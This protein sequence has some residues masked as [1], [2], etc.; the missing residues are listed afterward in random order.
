MWLAKLDTENELVNTEEKNIRDRI[1][2]ELEKIEKRAKQLGT[3][4][5]KKS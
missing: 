2:F 3:A 5:A 4:M 1:N